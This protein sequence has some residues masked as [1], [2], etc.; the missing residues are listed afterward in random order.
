MPE[1]GPEHPLTYRHEIVAPLF[2]LIR[3]RESCAI[4]GPASG[5]KSRLVQFILRPD[6]RRHYLG[7]DVDST[8]LVLADGNRV[9]EVSEWG[10]YELLLT[11][12]TE[13]SGQ[14]PGTQVLRDTLNHLRYEV[15]TG[16]NALLAR[17][18]TEL[19]VQMVCQEQGFRL[20]LILDE[21]DACYRALPASALANLRALRDTH[22]FRL[23]YVLLLRELPSRLRLPA[24]VEG[25]YELF[26]RSVFGLKP[27]SADDARRVISQLAARRG[28]SL[29]EKTMVELLRLSGG[30]PGI[31]VALFDI[32]ARN[33]EPATEDWQEWTWK[34]PQVQEEC[35][36]LWEGL[37]QDER[38]ALSHLAQEVGA[39]YGPRQSLELKGLIRS[40][41]DAYHF[42][43]PLFQRYVREQ[44]VL[45]AK[46]LWVDEQAAVVWMEGRQV[47]NLTPKE[48]DLLR[49]LY[50]HLGCVCSRGEIGSAIYPNEAKQEYYGEADN[51]ID[52]LVRHLRKKIEPDVAHP[53]YLLSIRGKGYKLVDTPEG[54]KTPESG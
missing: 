28:Y 25:F 13:A 6:V 49:Y 53:V 5:G 2:D 10:L 31:L 42:F 37:N 30:H 3:G 35:R 20:C 16:N 24:E 51:R 52:S 1:I 48:F 43:S 50:R 17:R 19:A 45:V 11:T 54:K 40:E 26:S 41:Q 36:K 7:D 46:P 22:K 27:Y 44:G 34:Q 18:H 39:A 33:Q 47:A 23:S 29:S 38:I 15:I 21:F 9:A 12:L 4:V 14:Y 32:M 8:L